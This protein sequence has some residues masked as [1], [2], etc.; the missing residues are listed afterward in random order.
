MLMAA[1]WVAGAGARADD[2]ATAPANIRERIGVYDSRAVAVAYAGSGVHNQLMGAL[3]AEFQRAKSQGDQTRTAELEA[4]GRARQK[5]LHMQGFSTEPVDDI[6]AQIKDALPPIMRQAGV[7]ALVSKWNKDGLA[8]HASAEQV[9]VTG[10]LID[11]FIPN[12]RQRK[13]AIEIQKH[14]PISLEQA[15]KID[16]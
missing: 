6:L 14:A 5:R 11:A 16:D 2:A 13:G 12:E 15:E 8:K 10:A 4:E 7:S 9:D 1:L 3:T